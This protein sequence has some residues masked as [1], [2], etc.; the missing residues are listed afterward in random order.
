M[1]Y[2]F[3]QV[4]GCAVGQKAGPDIVDHISETTGVIFSIV[5]S[6]ELSAPGVVQKHGLLTLA[7]NRLSH[8]AIKWAKL[9]ADANLLQFPTRG[10]SNG[11]VNSLIYGLRSIVML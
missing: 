2:V 4:S 6:V 1:S 10:P 3:G 5:S 7:P 11:A 8:G 9:W